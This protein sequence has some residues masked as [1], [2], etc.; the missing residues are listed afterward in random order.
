MFTFKST[1]LAPVPVSSSAPFPAAY[2]SSSPVST[3]CHFSAKAQCQ[4]T[5]QRILIQ[6]GASFYG[7]PVLGLPVFWHAPG[8]PQQ[9]DTKYGAQ[10]SELRAQ[11]RD[12][13]SQ[14]PE[15][16]PQSRPRPRHLRLFVSPPVDEMKFMHLDTSMQ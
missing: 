11:S 14:T 5:L 1:P 4:A 2:R 12:P 8:M 9:T 10:T 15:H 13:R 6:S 7:H 16:R 3:L